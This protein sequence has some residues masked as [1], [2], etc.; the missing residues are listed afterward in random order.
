MK[1][2]Y[3]CEKCGA[4][5][6]NYSEAAD[7]ERGH[8]APNTAFYEAEIESRIKWEK[9]NPI[10]KSMVLPFRS[11]GDD[12]EYVW[13]YA[14]YELGKRMDTS[15]VREIEAERKA[16]EQ[17]EEESRARWQAEREARKAREAQEQEAVGA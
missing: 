2:L 17:S 9:G 6:E 8:Q 10:P 3:V 1:E 15:E 4:M 12:G 11:Y 16:R 14:R 13:S 7:C 5:Y